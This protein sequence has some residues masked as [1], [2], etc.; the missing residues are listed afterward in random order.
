MD[1]SFLQQSTTSDLPSECYGNRTC[2]LI[3]S[4]YIFD[5]LSWSR[6]KIERKI[7]RSVRKLKLAPARWCAYT[8]YIY[9]S[10]PPSLPLKLSE[11]AKEL[12]ENISRI[13][14]RKIGSAKME[15]DLIC[16]IHPIIFSY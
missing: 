12:N 15:Y 8:L 4:L 16:I 1:L 5:K 11:D 6:L 3:D 10:L 9:I 14:T 2:F 13:M 7:K